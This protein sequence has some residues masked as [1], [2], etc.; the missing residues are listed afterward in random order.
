[1]IVYYTLDGFQ[2]VPVRDR[3][4]YILA[5]LIAYIIGSYGLVGIAIRTMLYTYM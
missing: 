1:M 2:S 4:N 3:Y 5:L